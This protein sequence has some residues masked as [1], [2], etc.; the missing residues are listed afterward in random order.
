MAVL[1]QILRWLSVHAVV[2]GVIAFGSDVATAESTA[3]NSQLDSGRQSFWLF[4]TTN[5]KTSKQMLED[6][7]RV[8]LEQAGAASASIE[9]KEVESSVATELERVLGRLEGRSVTQS[10]GGNQGNQLS[11]QRSYSKGREVWDIQLGSTPPCDQY[12]AK[13]E[14]AYSDR[15]EQFLA[16]EAKPPEEIENVAAGLVVVS[17]RNGRYEFW[18]DSSKGVPVKY[19][20]HLRSIKDDKEFSIEGSFPSL[21]RHY[22]IRIDNFSG[23]KN[24]LYEILCDKDRVGNPFSEIHEDSS[25]TIVFGRIAAE[26]P[27]AGFT[28]VGLDLVV[29]VPGLPGRSAARV[30][31][32]F[33]L[34]ES[35]VKDECARIDSLDKPSL[36][37]S[38]EIRKR[39][40]GERPVIESKG[41]AWYELKPGTAGFEARIRLTRSEK[42]FA[43]LLRDVPQAFR[44]LVWEFE[45]PKNPERRQAI[46]LDNGKLYRV[47]EVR[48]WKKVLLGSD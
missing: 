11:V 40:G 7:F 18:P 36:V 20:V 23:D 12:I 30:W 24:R 8:A 22:F 21:D 25:S 28:R 15:T 32:L 13:L 35:Q 16:Y 1:R 43:D 19:R 45:D 4:I 44:I 38:S 26:P 29:T 46:Y 41:P 2:F 27:R 48:D 5:P 14:V 6:T 34:T 3:R 33:P 39:V 9:V 31:M 37:L 10:Q 17:L 42:E 47:E